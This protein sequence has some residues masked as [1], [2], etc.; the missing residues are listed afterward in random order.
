MNGPI[1]SRIRRRLTVA[2]FGVLLLSLAAVVSVLI[3]GMGRAHRAFALSDLKRHTRLAARLISARPE[4]I[5]RPEQLSE[6]A[7]LID[8]D[9]DARVRVVNRRG[10]M[11]ADSRP[12]AELGRRRIK[13]IEPLR[14]VGGETVGLLEMSV[15]N[16]NAHLRTAPIVIAVLVTVAVTAV[17]AGGVVYWLAG[18]ITRPLA[19]L[20]EMA[21]AM[22]GGDL[23]QQVRTS[24]SDEIG[25]LAE[26]LNDLARQLRTSA[27]ELED[28]KGRL[29]TILASMTNGVIVTDEHGRVL[30]FNQA[31][32]RIFHRQ[33]H[34][35]ANTRLRDADLHP[36]IAAMVEACISTGS[37]DRREIRLPGR[38]EVTLSATASPL[39]HT[40]RETIG[41][42]VVLH[43]LT[44]IRKHEK[45]QREFVANVSHELRTPITA[46][47]VTAEALSSGA[48]EDPKLM[49]RFINSLVSESERI[50]ALIDDLLEIAKRD[51]RPKTVEKTRVELSELGRRAC[52]YWGSQAK[53]HGIKLECRLPDGIALEADPRQMDQLLDNLLSN[54][55][56]YT[57]RG[58]TVTVSA[59]AKDHT[60]D[61]SV[62]DTG[63]GIPQGDIPR[64]FER[65]YRVDKTRSRQLGG[66]GLGLSIVKD[67]VE[68]HGGTVTVESELG[69]G[70]TFTVSIPRW[71]E[72]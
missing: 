65:F 22:A 71:I 39:R 23:D 36:E 53:R 19:R 44:E 26:S 40:S 29:E 38:E 13:W 15:P 43:D 9:A 33:A 11:L 54:A 70:S 31:S 1:R 12:K 7:G 48:K 28:Q 5:E 55:I 60:V 64:V 58:G 20:N 67:I 42:V 2:H 69:R 18:G 8:R 51:A 57:P 21:R 25:Q 35:I 52:E 45:A 14:G 47:R 27:D 4:L 3:V 24:S 16:V 61:I 46:I 56:K 30:V 41:S 10:V 62:A 49:D 34:E 17:L 6:L 32:E 68:S 37:V 50:S 66:T 72:D 63:I 59:V